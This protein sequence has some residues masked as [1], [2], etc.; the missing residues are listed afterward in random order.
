VRIGDV[1]LALPLPRADAKRFSGQREGILT[2]R[3]KVFDANQLQLN[4]VTLNRLP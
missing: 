1:T 3:L 2:G 4:D